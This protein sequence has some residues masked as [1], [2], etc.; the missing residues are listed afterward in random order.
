MAKKQFK[1]ESKRLMDLMVNSIYTH[2]EIFLRDCWLALPRLQYYRIRQPRHFI[3]CIFT[4][5]HQ[6][7]TAPTRISAQ[8]TFRPVN[9]QVRQIS[10]HSNHRQFVDPRPI[11]DTARLRAA[12]GAC[13]LRSLSA[14]FNGLLTDAVS[15]KC[16]P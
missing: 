1:A 16:Q 2:K 4:L 13:A 7:G 8:Q 9:P 11:G 10:S 14:D 6:R 5:P 12:F 3:T 15:G